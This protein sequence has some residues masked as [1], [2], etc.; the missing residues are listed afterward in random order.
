MRAPLSIQSSPPDII[1]LHSSET[2]TV[3]GL[4]RNRN[5]NEKLK[6]FRNSRSIS[7]QLGGIFF[8]EVLAQALV[9]ATESPRLGPEGN[10]AAVENSAHC[11]RRRH[12]VV[13]VAC[14][15]DFGLDAELACK[16]HEPPPSIV[17]HR[18]QDVEDSTCASPMDSGACEQSRCLM[19]V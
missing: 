17:S 10:A 12:H 5:F 16:R 13:A 1:K 6:Y 8:A 7:R 9:P 11:A 4:T 15:L 19:I 2:C 14:D 3:V 18:R